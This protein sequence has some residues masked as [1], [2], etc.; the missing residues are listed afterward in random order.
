MKTIMI[1]DDING[2]P[3]RRWMIA[4]HP[5]SEWLNPKMTKARALNIS[6]KAA[7]MVQAG[8]QYGLQMSSIDLTRQGKSFS[9]GYS[10]G[11]STG[12]IYWYPRFLGGPNLRNARRIIYIYNIT[13]MSQTRQLWGS[14]VLSHKE[15]RINLRCTNHFLEAPMLLITS[16]PCDL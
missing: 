3:L 12:L 7:K 6:L 11:V 8:N 14:R 10:W 2:H 15:F 4:V 9:N 13:K 16:A 5:R 1:H